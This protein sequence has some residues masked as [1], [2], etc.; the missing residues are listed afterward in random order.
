GVFSLAGSVTGSILLLTLPGSVFRH[1]VPFLILGACV[2]V[3][4]QPRLAKRR[5]EPAAPHRHG[6]GWLRAAIGATGVYG[7]Y[8]GAAQGVILIALLGIFLDDD[9]QRLN[10]LKNVLATIANGIAAV[11]FVLFAHVAWGAAA[12]LAAGAVVGGQVGA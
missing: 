1:V 10:A 2:L 3:A 11:L 8:F 5:T 7:G 12:L 9:L 4:L 6:G